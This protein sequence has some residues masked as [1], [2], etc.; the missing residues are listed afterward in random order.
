[1]N[2]YNRV[3]I[4]KQAAELGFI[5]DS[6]EKVGLQ[7]LWWEGVVVSSAINVLKDKSF[8]YGAFDFKNKNQILFKTKPSAS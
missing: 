2:N 4:G 8:L 3:V 5:R 1:M 6:F 7:E